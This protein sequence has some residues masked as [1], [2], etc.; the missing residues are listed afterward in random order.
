[1]GNIIEIV[2]N[3][4]GKPVLPT[5]KY[6]SEKNKVLEIGGDSLKTACILHKLTDKIVK[7][8][9]DPE[10]AKQMLHMSISKNIQ[11]HIENS[12]VTQRQL[13]HKN[14]YMYQN[15]NIM[16]FKELSK[17][18]DI[19]FDTLLLNCEDDFY[20]ILQD[21][22]EILNNIT[23]IIMENRYNNISYKNYID[24]VLKKNNFYVDYVLCGGPSSGCCFDNFYEVWVLQAPIKYEL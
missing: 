6:L 10:L 3:L 13:I 18:Y 23:L 16:T 5:T 17:K 2:R 14:F 9:H 19:V 22:P 15:V 24:T 1:M 21:V 7:L 12:I 11:C 20:Y 4:T 8:E